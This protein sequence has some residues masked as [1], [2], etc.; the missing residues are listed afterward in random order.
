MKLSDYVVSALYEAGARHCF[1][2]PGGA[3]M[4]LNDSL[5]RSAL[6][7]TA[8]LHE[9]ASAIAAD[10]HAKV[11]NDL[12]LCMVT[13]GPGSTNAITGVAGAWLDSSPVAFVSGQVK[14]AD[15]KGDRGLRMLGVQEIDIVSLVKAITKYAV[16]VT[17]PADIRYHVEKAVH[18]AKAPR[19]GP[20][21]LDIPLDVQAAQ[22]E[23]SRLR[24][25]DPQEGG[26]PARPPDL[27]ATVAATVDLLRAAR[28]PVII[29][30]NGIRLAGAIGV[31]E[32]VVSRLGIPVLTTWL[33]LDL[34]PQD[35]PLFAGRPGSVAPRGANF[36]L[37]NSDLVLAVGARLDMA[38][39]AYAHENFARGARKVVV[40]IDRAEIG[41]LRM[42]IDVG[43]AAD[44]GD[45]LRELLRQL[46]PASLHVPSSWVERC[47]DW[48]RRYPV[49]LPEH[50]ARKDYVSTYAFSQV[51]SQELAEGDVVC[52]TSSGSAVEI[53]FLCYEA[54]KD[55]RVFHSRGLG[56]MGFALPSALG[57]C[58]AA[59][60]ARTVCV[61]G[62][63]GFQF[64]VHELETVRR[65]GLPIKIFV[66]SNEG[67]AS[68]RT[69]QQRYFQ[70]LVG[71]D[72][73]SGMTLPSTLAVAGAYGLRGTRIGGGDDLRAGI[74]HALAE[75]G[76]IVCEVLTPPDEPR[77]PSIVS[78]PRADGSMVSKPL[79][80]LWPFLDREEFR[81]NMIVP[82][83]AE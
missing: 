15:L 8:N 59:G 19:R 48:K 40:D 12:G 61:D 23:P 3:A 24:G 6:G 22:I 14:R 50:H 43:A 33:G 7:Y 9:Q 66:L 80:D 82:P 39:T 41:K 36:A 72:A 13:A 71:A 60:R 81:A 78:A 83:L 21:W 76:P 46:E 65:L 26:E 67:Y 35:H 52:P 32:K 56:A 42:D 69:S 73:T 4:H 49:V 77:Q 38:L 37:Q 16:T 79:E 34:I 31:F 20:V 44:A 30:G 45:F 11:T 47:Q 57:A 68:I 1:F 64:N 5:G 55:Q 63:G 75:P 17:E 27:A 29:A 2:V 58:L 51:L 74:R 53:F 25:F 54:K 28:R 70:R 10:A 18:L 62:D